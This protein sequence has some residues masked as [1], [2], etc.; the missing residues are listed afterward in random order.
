M[1]SDRG[2]CAASDEQRRYPRYEVNALV[3]LPGGDH[4]PHRVQNISLGG[5]SIATAELAEVG[6]V[7][8]LVVNFPDLD[9]S[10]LR[11]RGQVVWANREPPGDLGI[12]W[13]ELDDGKRELLRRYLDAVIGSRPG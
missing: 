4:A 3:E 2:A 8:E 7:V 6:T 11:A 13:L 1:S 5:L 9:G 10:A 12:R